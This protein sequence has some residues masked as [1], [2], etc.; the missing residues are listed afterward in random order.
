M[1]QNQNL[2]HN[3]HHNLQSHIVVGQ[4][5]YLNDSFRIISAA[6]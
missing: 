6:P 2:H 3:S 5:L 1:R 4:M